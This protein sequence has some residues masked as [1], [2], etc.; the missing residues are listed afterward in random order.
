M[1]NSNIENIARKLAQEI[2]QEKKKLQSEGRILEFRV[3]EVVKENI[4]NLHTI[5]GHSA[6]SIERLYSE[7]VLDEDGNPKYNT[8]GTPVLRY[9]LSLALIFQI[10]EEL[11]DIEKRLEA[12]KLDIRVANKSLAEKSL[13]LD[14]KTIETIKLLYRLDEW[15]EFKISEVLEL[16]VELILEIINE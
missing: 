7:N 3:S 9:S 10:L 8:D 6:S 11:N 14:S 5:C 15:D 12:G 1:K 4:R 16:P 2:F 13:K